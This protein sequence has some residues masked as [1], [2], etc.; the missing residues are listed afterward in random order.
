MDQTAPACGIW[1]GWKHVPRSPAENTSPVYIQVHSHGK[2]HG[3]LTF[4]GS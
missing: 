1:K 4:S 3:K 2:P